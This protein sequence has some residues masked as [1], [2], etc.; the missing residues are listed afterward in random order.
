MRLHP[1]LLL[2]ALATL[3]AGA[4]RAQPPPDIAG[5]RFYAFLNITVGVEE[6]LPTLIRRE[7]P[8]DP[9]IWPQVEQYVSREFP[10]A[11]TRHGSRILSRNAAI[12][13]PMY[14][15][16]SEIAVAAPPPVAPP[17]PPPPPQEA[18]V[19]ALIEADEPVLREG[20]QGQRA[21][22]LAIDNVRRGDTLVT[23]PRSAASL[24]L[25]DGTLILMRPDSAVQ[26]KDFRFAS[27]D[28]NAG[29]L[30][31]QLLRGAM[32]TVS[33]MIS[34]DPRSK[35]LLETPGGNVTVRGTD[36]AVRW[37][38]E[39]GSCQ[40][41]GE[42]VDGGLYAGVLEGGIDLPNSRGASPA[43]AGDIV[44]VASVGEGALPAPEMAPLV[45]TPPELEKLPKK[46]VPKVETT[47][48]R[49]PRNNLL[50]PC[51]GR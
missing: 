37:C 31:I 34:K 23:T 48:Q 4:A 40:L 22:I 27:Q 46:V 36:Y 29:A 3:L 51:I 6:P 16:P 12:R 39:K 47:C 11:F 7:L 20:I 18:I 28:G 32:R 38:P 13:L 17:P 26:I 25:L 5:Y 21:S 2:I 9:A 15:R 19:G 33:G 30:N 10:Q 14:R 35:Y 42:E 45:F 8:E 49:G 24:R 50:G 43:N 1:L 41:K 44:R